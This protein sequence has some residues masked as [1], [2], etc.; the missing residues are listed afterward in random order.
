[1]TRRALSKKTQ[2]IA[3]VFSLTQ[4]PSLL[5]ATSISVYFEYS[6]LSQVDKT[7]DPVRNQN[8]GSDFGRDWRKDWGE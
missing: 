8:Q 3:T 7:L 5:L 1:M 6:D 2:Q 4:S